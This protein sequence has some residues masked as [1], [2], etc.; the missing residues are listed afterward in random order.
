MTVN[1]WLAR[2][3]DKLAAGLTAAD[4]DQLEA[5]LQTPRQQVLYLYSKSTNMR[6]PLAS[7]ALYDPTVQQEPVLPESA[8]PYESVLAALADGWRVV[9][10]PIAKL[11]DYEGQDNDY[12]GFEFVLE[13]FV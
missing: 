4:L 9:Q 2:S 7:W 5:L 3:R 13:K 10:F 11:Y 8:P 12:L 1:D 6:S